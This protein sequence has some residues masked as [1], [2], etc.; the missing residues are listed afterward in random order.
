MGQNLD[1]RMF[2]IVF[3]NPESNDRLLAS[4]SLS[5]MNQKWTFPRS[6]HGRSSP[7]NRRPMTKRTEFGSTNGGP[8]QR[9]HLPCDRPCVVI[10]TRY[11]F[12]HAEHDERLK[13]Y[14]IQT[15]LIGYQAISN[16]KFRTNNCQ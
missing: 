9:T 16:R 2:F 5:Q 7:S 12:L 15:V 14:Q 13:I 1:K 10:P 3:K 6:S 11:V 4:N 8:P